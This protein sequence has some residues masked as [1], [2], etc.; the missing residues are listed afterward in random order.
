MK[1]AAIRVLVI[2]LTAALLA[3]SVASSQDVDSVPYVRTSGFNAPALLGWEDQSSHSI[4]Q[5]HLPSA[6]ASIRTAMVAAEDPLLGARAD[7][8]AWLGV[9]IGEP[10]SSHKV[11]LADGTWH[12]LV[13]DIDAET[14]ASLMARRAGANVVVISFVEAMP[15]SRTVMLTLPQADAE[16]DDAQPEMA[17]ALAEMGGLDLNALDAAGTAALPSGDWLTYESAELRVMGMVFGNDSYIAL[18]SGQ[19]GD[20]ASLADAYNRALLGFFITPDNSLYLALGLAVS[21]AILGLLLLSWLWRARQ[22]NKDLAMLS[23]LA[24]AS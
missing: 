19:L 1:T 4:A 24:E 7:L 14:T 12:A 23:E 17:L 15:D 11:N 13:F 16:R 22:I 3:V 2:C 18:Q 8:A 21:F 6:Q 20:L 9:T 5:F 10:V